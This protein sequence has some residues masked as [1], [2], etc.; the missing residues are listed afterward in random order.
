M[1]LQNATE[2]IISTFGVYQ[3]IIDHK[4]AEL[5]AAY[6][7]EQIQ[8]IKENMEEDVW[9]AAEYQAVEAAL[10]PGDS[11]V[12]YTD[13]L[14]E[15]ERADGEEFG[16]ERLLEAARRLVNKPLANEVCLFAEDGALDR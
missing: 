16:K 11:V 4:E 7:F 10:E 9:V 3:D 15:V 8:R 2:K 1:P 13:G 5:K 6:Y 12:M 14:Y